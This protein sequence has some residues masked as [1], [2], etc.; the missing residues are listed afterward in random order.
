VLVLSADVKYLFAELLSTTN[1][2]KQ[3]APYGSCTLPWLVSQLRHL[4]TGLHCGFSFAERPA[5]AFTDELCLT[6]LGELAK[7]LP[8]KSFSQSVAGIQPSSSSG[9]HFFLF[10][11]ISSG[12]CLIPFWSSKDGME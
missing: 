5:N 10:L 12:V 6:S 9:T 8:V 11:L 4:S 2:L 1:I 7:L 3:V